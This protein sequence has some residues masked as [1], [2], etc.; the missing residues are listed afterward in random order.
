MNTEWLTAESFERNQEVISA[1]NALSIHAKLRMAGVKDSPV[2]ADVAGAREHLK[3]FLGRIGDLVRDI[4]ADQEAPVLGTDPRLSLLAR[5]FA[6]TKKQWAAPAPLYTLSM[7]E[8]TALIDS[9]R[10][11]DQERLIECLR[12]L[13]LLVEEHAYADVVG[14][15]GEM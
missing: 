4:E 8:V 15:L 10:P 1:I 11:E 2:A 5:Q 14:L 13:R 7:E 6:T 3:R 9:D 12:A